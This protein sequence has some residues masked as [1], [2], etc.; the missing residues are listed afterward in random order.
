MSV[1]S[2]VFLRASTE[3]ITLML[4]ASAASDA[5]IAA[6]KFAV[7]VSDPIGCIVPHGCP[8]PVRRQLAPAPPLYGQLWAGRSSAASAAC[9]LGKGTSLSGEIA[10]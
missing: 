2:V 1:C 4:D 3:I 6:T 8:S 7:L 9:G 10:E 5:A